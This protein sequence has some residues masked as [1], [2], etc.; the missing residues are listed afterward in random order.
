MDTEYDTMTL[1]LPQGNN[2]ASLKSSELAALDL[3][4]SLFGPEEAE[5]AHKLLLKKARRLWLQRAARAVESGEAVLDSAPPEQHHLIDLTFGSDLVDAPTMRSLSSARLLALK[6]TGIGREDSELCEDALEELQ[7]RRRKAALLRNGRE[8]SI[9]ARGTPEVP[10]ITAVDTHKAGGASSSLNSP[11]IDS[12]LEESSAAADR[13][14]AL[15]DGPHVSTEQLTDDTL[16]ISPAQPEPQ[17]AVTAPEFIA[18]ESSPNPSSVGKGL[19]NPRSSTAMRSPTLSLKPS[20]TSG[21]SKLLGLIDTQSEHIFDQVSDSDESELSMLVEEHHASSVINRQPSS[22]YYPQSVAQP[23]QPVNVD[24]PTRQESDEQKQALLRRKLEMQRASQRDERMGQRTNGDRR[25]APSAVGLV[26]QGQQSQARTGLS[27]RQEEYAARNSMQRLPDRPLQ[28]DAARISASRLPPSPVRR[29]RSRS[30]SPPPRRMRSLT[31]PRRPRSPIRDAPATRPDPSDPKNFW[32]HAHLDTSGRGP[33]S[34]R[35]AVARPGSAPIVEM[36]APKHDRAAL[37]TAKPIDMMS[38]QRS[39]SLQVQANKPA[40]K[41]TRA[42]PFKDPSGLSP[43][44]FGNSLTVVPLSCAPAQISDTA[45]AAPGQDM[46]LLELRNQLKQNMK[47]AKE[48]HSVDPPEQESRP[49]QYLEALGHLFPVSFAPV[50]EEFGG[51][52]FLSWLERI[53]DGP[54]PVALM[55]VPSFNKPPASPNNTVFAWYKTSA[56]AI[57]ARSKNNSK[58]VLTSKVKLTTALGQPSQDQIDRFLQRIIVDTERSWLNSFAQSVARRKAS[59]AAEAQIS[60]EQ[61]I[62]VAEPSKS[63]VERPRLTPV[64]LDSMAE[65]TRI[66]SESAA[67][68]H[69]TVEQDRPAVFERPRSETLEYVQPASASIVEPMSD[70]AMER[71]PQT[72]VLPIEQ[73]NQSAASN[74]APTGPRFVRRPNPASSLPM[75]PSPSTIR[76][77][78]SLPGASTMASPAPSAPAAQR[79]VTQE[80][81]LPITPTEP[82]MMRQQ[83]AQITKDPRLQPRQPHPPKSEVPVQRGNNVKPSILEAAFYTEPQGDEAKNRLREQLRA[84]QQEQQRYHQQINAAEAMAQSDVGYQVNIKG[85]GTL[86]HIPSGPRAS[87]ISTLATASPLSLQDR[88]AAPTPASEPLTLSERID[89]ALPLNPPPPSLLDRVALGNGNAPV[90]RKRAYEADSLD[91]QQRRQPSH[92]GSL[93]DR[94]R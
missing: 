59:T 41:P 17:R 30:R 45:S 25:E 44:T 81:S 24:R 8:R 77:V 71:P 56:D 78:E 94:L 85:S 88:M 10:V 35:P 93:L 70:Q 38:A 9:S 1:T 20:P 48:D 42:G 68:M 69:P 23:I 80:G 79:S 75:R 52:T 74:G 37:P 33:S 18:F 72:A 86:G 83:A 15:T 43:S 89:G 22:R 62:S 6:F 66:A 67:K 26:R 87:T 92:A 13:L 91:D 29:G 58:C 28:S 16:R 12:V 11:S 36:T 21:P 64:Q 90:S 65:A 4:I 73:P 49:D 40:P 60:P 32:K 2:L 34:E 19:A 63:A 3:T 61:A 14:N 27:M 50:D 5:N 31:P 57:R 84:E 55:V 46:T 39:S 76:S 53:K 47:K 54:L 7:V 82:C 51:Q